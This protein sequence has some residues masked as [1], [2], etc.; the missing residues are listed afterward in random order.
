[1]IIFGCS[2]EFLEK[3]IHFWGSN[4]QIGSDSVFSSKKLYCGVYLNPQ[5]LIILNHFTSNEFSQRINSFF[6]V[7]KNASHDFIRQ[8]NDISMYI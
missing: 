3:K 4:D 6:G 1:M 8:N 7:K 5:K 2:N